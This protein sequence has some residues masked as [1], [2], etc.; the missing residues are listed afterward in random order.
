MTDLASEALNRARELAG[1]L[2]KIEVGRLLLLLISYLHCST[3]FGDDHFRHD[4]LPPAAA[5]TLLYLVTAPQQLIT[6]TFRA[7]WIFLQP[8]IS[9][10][11]QDA[12]SALETFNGVGRKLPLGELIGYA[13]GAKSVRIQCRTFQFSLMTA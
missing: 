13:P 4:H 12:T 7:T 10:F 1:K 11:L 6:V 5:A 2:R 3:T 8:L 9:R